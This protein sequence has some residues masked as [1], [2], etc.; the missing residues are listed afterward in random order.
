MDRNLNYQVEV[1]NILRKMACSIKTIYY[2]RDFLPEETRLFLLNA[3]MI[4]YLQY[5]SVLL[6]G[7]SQGLIWTLEKRLNW[8]IKA[9]FNR[10]KMDSA[11][12]LRLKHG[13]ISVRKTL[14][15][16]A[17]KLF[18]KWK[19]N[20]LPAFSQPILETARMTKLYYRAHTRSEQMRNSL[21]KRVVPL[22]NV[23][24]DK[25]KSG[26]QTYDTLKK[27]LKKFLLTN[28]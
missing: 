16:N 21:F 19:H 22:W 17:I 4:S 14:D 6:N 12:D 26:N 11:Q 9:C 10:Y 27:R 1:K 13:I 25:M 8:G 28:R 24:H 7:I 18:W 2:I 20:L 15:M 5:S 3:L 23:L